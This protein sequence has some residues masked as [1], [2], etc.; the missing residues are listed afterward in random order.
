MRLDL[1][2]G[3]VAH[4]VDRLVETGGFLRDELRIEHGARRFVFGLEHAFHEARHHRDVPA[5]AHLKV[6]LGNLR[7]FAERHLLLRSAGWRIR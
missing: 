2:P 4:E 3:R 1:G 6:F 5:G 7:R